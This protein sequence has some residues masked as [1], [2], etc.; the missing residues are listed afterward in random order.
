VYRILG[1]DR[2][3][4]ALYAASMRPPAD[5]PLH[6]FT[7]KALHL[8]RDIGILAPRARVELLDG[9]LVDMHR[10]T[11]RELAVTRRV[12]DVLARSL[13]ADVVSDGPIH[14]EAYATFDATIMVHD[15]EHLPLT[16]PWLL[17]RFSIE[18]YGR[19]LATGILRDGARH[20]LLDGVVFDRRRT[21][22]L[23]RCAPG[24]ARRICALFPD[25]VMRIGEAVVLGPYSRLWLD[26]AFCG[27]R[28]D[29]YRA[30]PPTGQDVR[31]AIDLDDAQSDIASLLR[32]PVYA[33]WG[34][35]SGWIMRGE[36]I[37]EMFVR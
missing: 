15:W 22:V 3:A 14:P 30:G 34:V 1:S 33:R 16:A 36:M 25:A 13:D 24:L 5:V 9:I 37:E 18:D 7:V 4:P 31:V 29:G 35:G 2:D 23:A 20:E 27:G 11:A 8:M 26:V 6:R 32:W 12:A 21:H 10:P 19:M 17:H 28:A